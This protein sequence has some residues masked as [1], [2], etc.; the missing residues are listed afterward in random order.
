MSLS[1]P[2][3]VKGA[4]VYGTP[5]YNA[6]TRNWDYDTDFNDGDKLPPLSPRFVYLRQE[7]FVREY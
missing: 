6:P 1:T 3:H 4:W 2:K 7:L 5:Q